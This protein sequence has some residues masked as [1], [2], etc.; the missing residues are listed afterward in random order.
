MV[1]MGQKDTGF[2]IETLRPSHDA[3]TFISFNNLIGWPDKNRD[4]L[5]SLLRR[6]EVLYHKCDGSIHHVLTRDNSVTD[7]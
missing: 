6:A 7:L 1:E 5:L 2:Q 3:S 4:K